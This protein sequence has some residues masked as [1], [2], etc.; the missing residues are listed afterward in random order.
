VKDDQLS[1]IDHV[2]PR[3]LGENMNG[4]MWLPPALLVTITRGAFIERY[5]HDL[6][7]NPKAPPATAVYFLRGSSHR[8]RVEN[9]LIGW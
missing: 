8:I 7:Q 6:L 4:K 3:S 5:G 1:T 2:I 9:F